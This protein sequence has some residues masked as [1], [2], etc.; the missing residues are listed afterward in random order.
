M[1][2]ATIVPLGSN[3]IALGLT[4]ATLWGVS[5]FLGGVAAR[6]AS[7]VVVV[8]V[9]HSVSLGVLSLLATTLHPDLPDRHIA[10]WALVTGLT[11]GI[12]VILFYRAL[13]L[14]EMG[15]TAALTG[16]LTALVP[17]VVSWITEG[18]PS[19]SQLVGFVIAAVAIC[20][21]AYQPAQNP[22]PQRGG[23]L[24]GTIAGLGFGAFLVASKYA[25]PQHSNYAAVLWPLA[26][27]RLAS[28][29]VAVAI[30]LVSRWRSQTRTR[31]E[32]RLVNRGQVHSVVIVLSLAGSAG[33]LEAWGN[34]LYMLS[35]VSGRLDVAAVLSSLYPAATILLAIWLLK[36]RATGSK[37]LGMA[38]ALLA[39]VVISL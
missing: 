13:A 27:S 10:L 16:V 12:A 21:I 18:R 35:T 30:V 2:G 23:L 29:S 32:Q 26:Y 34:L 20:L 31:T 7:A 3:V 36:E 5:D 28:A 39:V 22:R 15:L 38:L 6:R 25:S 33:L 37:A 17:V 9:A 11:G 24:L 1:T 4:A 19:D 14:G 8:A